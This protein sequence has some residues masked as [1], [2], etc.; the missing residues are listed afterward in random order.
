MTMTSDLARQ[1]RTALERLFEAARP[2]PGALMVLG[3]STSALQGRRIGKAGRPELAREVLEGM[4]G[5]LA[6]AGVELAVQ[7]CEHVNRALV[8]AR[9][10]AERYG[11]REVRVVPVPRAGGSLAAVWRTLLDDPVVVEDLRQQATLG[12]DLGGVL[13]G[14]HLRPVVVPVHFADL[15]VGEARVS[16]GYSRPPLVGGARAVYSEE[17]ADRILNEALQ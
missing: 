3:G 11:L 8:V 7:G 15:R 5:P 13:I 14:M 6:R 10:V 1:A 12:L 2:R 16:G 9:P 17:E 4:M